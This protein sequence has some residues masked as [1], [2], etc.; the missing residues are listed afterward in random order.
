MP[1]IVAADRHDRRWVLIKAKVQP[2]APVNGL[3]AAPPAFVRLPRRR[4]RDLLLVWIRFGRFTQ[5]IEATA[6]RVVEFDTAPWPKAPGPLPVLPYEQTSAAPVG[7]SQRCQYQKALPVRSSCSLAAGNA[8]TQR[9]I[10]TKSLTGSGA[11][12]GALVIALKPKVDS[13]INICRQPVRP[14]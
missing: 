12:T 4:A 8:K 2:I 6:V 1:A 10:E 3:R 5:G 13:A 11:R 14:S 7:M 9:H